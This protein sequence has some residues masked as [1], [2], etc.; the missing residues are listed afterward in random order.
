MIS[1]LALA[2]PARAAPFPADTIRAAMTAWQVPGLAVAVVEGDRPA[3]LHTF[4]V[5]DPAT[6]A[7][8]TPRT[9]FALGSV[10]KSFTV[11]ALS[12]LADAGRLDW[13]APVRRYMPDFRLY[14]DRLTETVTARDLVTHRTG[15]PRHDALWSLHAY[16]GTQLM[17]RLRFLKPA[18]PLRSVYA[19]N[20]LMV[21]AAGR[22]AGRIAGGSWAALVRD[23]ILEPL[24]M[25]RT[26]VSTAAFA[27][28][29]DRASPTFMGDDGRVATPLADVDPIG[30]A[31][32]VYSDIA[33]MGV[34]LRMLVNRGEAAGTRIVSRAA[35]AEMETPQ[36]A[37]GPRGSDPSVATPSYGLGLEIARY[38][39][40]PL[41]RHPGVIDGYAA[42]LAVL[43]DDNKGVVVLSDMSGMNPVPRVVAYAVIDSLLGLAPQPWVARL[44]ERRRTWLAAR[45][46]AVAEKARADAEAS[47]RRTPPPRPL[48]AYAGAYDNPAYG[49]MMI[50]ADPEDGGLAG[51]LHAVRFTLVHA[52]GDDWVVPETEWPLRAGLVMHFAFDGATQAVSLA[53][54]LADGPTYRLK[55]GDLVFR[56]AAD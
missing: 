39:G 2:L 20:N 41:V 6:G 48:A 13:D 18:A 21:A 34:Y 42:I 29:G 23:R 11:I 32:G 3:E 27:V 15:I 4:G 12:Q 30:P 36:I 10:S 17:A 1:L 19:Y 31:A 44:V 37:I 5:R 26:R 28:D 52:T 7:P 43:P 47:A 46:A 33:D 38:R 53:T 25:H 40:H 22:V 8:V 56:R 24:G 50:T 35:I 9:E 49:R 14:T 45:A 54:P 55:A 16:D 51:A